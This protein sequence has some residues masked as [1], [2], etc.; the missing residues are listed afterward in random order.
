MKLM[1][2]VLSWLLILPLSGFAQQGNQTAVPIVYPPTTAAENPNAMDGLVTGM[3][4]ETITIKSQAANPVSFAVNKKVQYT[5]Q[6]G[7][8][9]KQQRIK[10]GM[11]V[12]IYYQGTE[13]T[14]TALKIVVQ[15]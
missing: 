11:R 15:K 7:R 4:H 5:D 2:L 9:I 1:L 10:D 3:T 14:R 12:R 13:D 6:K 8:K